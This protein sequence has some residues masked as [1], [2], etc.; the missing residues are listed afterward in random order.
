MKELNKSKEKRI[1][2]A[3]MKEKIKERDD[4]KQD[5][6]SSI[7]EL[8]ETPTKYPLN[9]PKYKIAKKENES[10]NLNTNEKKSSTPF[11]LINMKVILITIFLILVGL[12]V[13]DFINFYSQELKRNE[14]DIDN[15]K[16]VSNNTLIYYFI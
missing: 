6:N 8:K 7:N 16:K 9:Q 5:H 11:E 10:N 15:C 1:D 3:K 12:F 2:Y 4:R 14:I 13:Y